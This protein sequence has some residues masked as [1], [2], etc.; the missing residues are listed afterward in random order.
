MHKPSVDEDKVPIERGDLGKRYIVVVGSWSESVAS[1]ATLKCR[2]P[3][4][5]ARKSHFAA[6][7]NCQVGGQ[8]KL[9]R[10]LTVHTC[11]VYMHCMIQ[12]VHS[13]GEGPIVTFQG[14]EV[15]ID[16][17]QS[18]ARPRPPPGGSGEGRKTGGVA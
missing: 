18:P 17:N 9:A 11:A 13:V 2:S 10:V 16:T 7:I 4:L 15:F 14:A 6:S 3:E 8:D 5:S 1:S 12:T